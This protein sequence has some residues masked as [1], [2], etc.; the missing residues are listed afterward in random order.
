MPSDQ[1]QDDI[2]ESQLELHEITN[3]FDNEIAR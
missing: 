3:D 2:N 1:E